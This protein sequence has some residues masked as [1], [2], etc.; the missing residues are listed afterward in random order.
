MSYSVCAL[1][2]FASCELFVNLARVCH[3]FVKPLLTHTQPPLTETLPNCCL[4]VAKLLTTTEQ[5]VK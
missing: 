5:M 2:N 1:Q 4:P 3:R